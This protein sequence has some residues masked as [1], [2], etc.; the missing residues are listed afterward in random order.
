MTPLDAGLTVAAALA[1]TIERRTGSRRAT[2]WVV[3]GLVAV[4]AIWTFLIGSSARPTDLTFEDVKLDRIPAMTSW[5][6]LEGELRPLAGAGGH[7]YELHDTADDRLYVIVIADAPLELGHAVVTGRLSPGEA[8]VGNIGSIE[9]DIPAVPKRNEPFAVILLP[10]AIGLLVVLGMRL[11]YP[12]V[13]RGRSGSAVRA[14]P[15][16]PGERLAVRWSGRI[17]SEGI[18]R[19][20]PLAATLAVAP[21]PG[22]IEVSLVVADGVRT[23]RV[24]RAAPTRL[25]R[26]CRIGGCEPALEI[27]TQSADVLVGFEDRASR[28]RL[29]ATLA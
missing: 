16:G 14:V 12:V 4:S 25:I 19:D 28:D 6:R 9:A 7:L 10:A 1:H 13:R 15:L 22:L 27:F 26:L 23:V 11:G 2:W 8:T 29:A 5:A 21:E 24:R 17:G 20:R 18:P 3:A